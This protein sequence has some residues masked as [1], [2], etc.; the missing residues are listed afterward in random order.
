MTPE[1]IVGVAVGDLVPSEELAVIE[2]HLRRALAGEVVLFEREY[3]VNRDYRCFEAA[4][5]PEVNSITQIVEGIHVMIREV[6]E[7]KLR[8][9]ELSK[10]AEL[11]H[12]TQLLNRKGFD[13]GLAR[14][15]EACRIQQITVGAS[16]GL[17][18]STRGSGSARELFDSADEQLYKVK[19]SGR[20]ACSF[21]PR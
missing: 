16:A 11:V 18:V 15:L 20:G 4:Y 14:E 10:A 5:R 1:K 7:S 19:R 9:L 21:S 13:S 8:L 3:G 2:P 6:T 12:L 17:A